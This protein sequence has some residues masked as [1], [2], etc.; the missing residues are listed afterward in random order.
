MFKSKDIQ[1]VETESDMVVAV[2]HKEVDM[3]GDQLLQ[4]AKD[5]IAST[6]PDT[7][8][9][10]LLKKSGFAAQPEVI[11]SDEEHRKL[12]FAEG[13]AQLVTHFAKRYPSYKF[14][15]TKGIQG[16]A[17]KYNLI[18]GRSELFTGMVPTKNLEEIETFNDIKLYPED[19]F[20]EEYCLIRDRGTTISYERYK[21]DSEEK[22][23]MR[24]SGYKDYK[25]RTLYRK[26]GL[27]VM[28]PQD[29]F[30]LKNARINRHGQI[31]NIPKDPIVLCPVK[32]GYL[33]V[34][35]WGVEAD[36]DE[37]K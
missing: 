13:E 9:A 36:Y 35:K 21:K 31:E 30:N 10:K 1:V 23:D 6:P 26:L 15:S 14:I 37:F 19:C 29:Q 28:A 3:F 4:Q 7:L 17:K 32:G 27:E 25:D 18:F 22:A 11:K 20:Y 16:I 8:R 33:V 12:K 24:A 34:T 5:L 2:I